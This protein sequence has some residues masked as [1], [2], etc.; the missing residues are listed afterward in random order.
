MIGQSI[1]AVNQY[2]TAL[3]TQ[4]APLSTDFVN[5]MTQEVELL[6]ARL[7]KDMTNAGENIQPQVQQMLE[8]LQRQAEELRER[9]TLYAESVDPEAVKATVMQK[10]EELKMMLTRNVNNLQAQMVPITEQ[11]KEKMD[12]S[13]DEFQKTLVPLAKQFET[14]VNVKTQEL[15]QSLAQRGEQLRT[16]LDASTQDLQAQLAALWETFNQ[17]TQ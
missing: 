4:V 14:E 17:R 9:T 15:Q 13:L 5:R 7:E 11:V 2:S 16:Q 1:D 3:R 12:V 8:A 10:T 6:K